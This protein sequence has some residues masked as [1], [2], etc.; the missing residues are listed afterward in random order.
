MLKHL[1][2]AAGTA[3]LLLVISAGG[4]LIAAISLNSSK[5][6]IYRTA[7]GKPVPYTYTFNISIN[8]DALSVDERKKILAQACA[9]AARDIK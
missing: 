8:H 2:I 5:S 6:N 7:T 3:A 9:D 4:Y 1:A